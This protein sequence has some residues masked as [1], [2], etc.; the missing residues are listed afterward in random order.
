[1]VPRSDSYRALLIGEAIAILSLPILINIKIFELFIFK[2]VNLYLLL[3]FWLILTPLAVLL[4]LNLCFRLSLFYSNVFYEIGKY[5]IVGCL[6][7]F[8]DAG[9]LNLFVLISGIARG[10][11][12]VV[13][14]FFSFTITISQ[15]F[16]WNKFWI[17]KAG[18]AGKTK[19]EYLK[20]FM[21]TASISLINL[22]LFNLL[23]NVIGA[24][25]IIDPKIWVNISFAVLFPISL[26]GN[27]FGSKILV[28][29]KERFDIIK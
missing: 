29:K 15:S 28:F 20:Y 2:N 26:F 11:P 22:F 18:G 19:Q 13:F 21:V 9:I 23:V 17:F 16:F 27:F 6:N 7:T 10:W 1:M 12:V 5:G 8:L 4:W 24:P 14:L 25:E 3:I